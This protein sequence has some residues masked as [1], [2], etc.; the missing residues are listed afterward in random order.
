MRVALVSYYFPEYTVS[1]A[2]ALNAQKVQMLLMLPKQALEALRETLAPGIEVRPLCDRRL[3]DPSNVL[4]TVKLARTIHAWQP[5]LIHLQQGHMWFNLVALSLLSR[6]RLVTTVHDVISHAGDRYSRQIPQWIWNIAIRRASHL[7]VHGEALKLQLARR[8]PIPESHVHV[9]P[10][11]EFSFYARWARPDCPER[12]HVLF[13]GRI[14]PYKGL[15]Y[16]IQAEPLIT[17]Q[18]PTARIVI[19]GE[20]ESLADYERM[21]IHRDR[22]VVHNRFIPVE[23]VAG[24]F[25]QAA[26]VVLPYVEASQSGV[27]PIAYAFGKPVV[28]TNVGSIPEAVEPGETGYLV[29]PRDVPRLADAVV[30]LLKDST[31]RRYMGKRAYQKAMTDL[32]WEN[33]ASAI[34]KVY[35]AALAT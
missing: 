22:F 31:L 34:F 26:L 13:F 4:E 23:Q 29:P 16:L 20:G 9:I 24:L 1:L 7:I 28:A 19:A 17:D 12:D 33:I 18:V 32:S 8:H 2:N 21:M 6:Q 27:I 3:R 11:G 10:H 15:Q 25:Q 14:W 5:D 35:E 30:H